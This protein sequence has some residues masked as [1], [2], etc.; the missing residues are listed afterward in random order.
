M[1]TA[2]RQVQFLC[3]KNAVFILKTGCFW[4]IT[5][6]LTQFFSRFPNCQR[7]L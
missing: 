1:K 6:Y 4:T 7:S 3:C 5:G 2:S